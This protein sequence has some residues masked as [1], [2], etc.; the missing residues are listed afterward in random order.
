M[1][2][3]LFTLL[4]LGVIAGVSSCRKDSN[5]DIDIKTYDEQQ[6]QAYISS[7]GLS[8]FTRD[9]VGGDTSGIYYKII[10]QGTGKT[11]DYPD[12][13]SVVFTIKSFDGQYKFVDTLINHI[14]DFVGH[15]TVDRWKVPGAGVQLAIL[16]ILKN[17]GSSAR[18]LIPSRLGYG[19]NGFGSG[20]SEAT[21][22]VAGNQSLDMYISVIDDA[23]TN[24]TDAST[25]KLLTGQDVYDDMVIAN[26]IAHNNLTGYTQ[27]PSGLWYKITK[28]GSTD[29]LTAQMSVDLQWT[30]ALLN[31][32]RTGNEYNN[33]T[34]TGYPVDL[35]IDARRAVVEA[36]PKAT[37]GAKLTF[38]APTRLMYGYSTSPTL[39]MP[40]LSCLRYDINVIGITAK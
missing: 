24:I 29:V 17:K 25:G 6:I 30:E 10:K 11:L 36:V 19:K 2:R 18:V 26:Y 38:L 7:N 35:S 34:G 14:Y 37:P 16:N 40:V 32:A 15:I 8:G 23:N 39:N 3:I 20:S 9:L 13:V 28:Q 27:T 31:G 5:K 1:K 4:L 33:E 12:K 21:S 22:R